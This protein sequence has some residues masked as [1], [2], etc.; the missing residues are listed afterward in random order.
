MIIML[1]EN[2]IIF[3]GE[4]K[5]SNGNISTENGEYI[6]FTNNNNIINLI[7]QKDWLNSIENK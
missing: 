6:L 2:Q 3:S 7:I 5:K 4:I 1:D